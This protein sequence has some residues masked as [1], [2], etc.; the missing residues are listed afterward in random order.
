MSV[1][2][3]G[4]I[5]SILSIRT[6]GACCPPTF[7]IV[8]SVIIDLIA[9][10]EHPEPFTIDHGV[11]NENVLSIGANDKSEPFAG[12]KPFDFTGDIGQYF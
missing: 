11:V 3:I 4:P 6:N 9:I 10:F 5:R 2:V 1:L 8:L 7:F 12:V